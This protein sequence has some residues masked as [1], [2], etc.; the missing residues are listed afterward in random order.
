MSAFRQQKQA[1]MADLDLLPP[2]RARRRIDLSAH[3]MARNDAV[4]A[5]FVTVRE[6]SR[7]SLYQ[8]T[9]QAS[10]SVAPDFA[11]YVRAVVTAVETRLQRLSDVAFSLLVAIAFVSIFSLAGQLVFGSGEHPEI[12]AKPLDFTHV[13]LTPQDRNGMRVLLLNAIVENRTGRQVTLPKLRADLV[14]N[15]QVVAST[16]ID[17]PVATLEGGESRGIVTRLQ[18]PGGKIPEVRLSFEEAGA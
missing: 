5:Q 1:A 10:A 6:P 4:D 2:D 7:P 17:P 13:N 11:S 12:A 3:R 16:Y 8:A 14:L 15:G 18:H 9:P